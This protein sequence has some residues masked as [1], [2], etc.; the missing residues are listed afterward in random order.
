[1]AIIKGDLEVL[2]KIFARRRVDEGLFNHGSLTGNI[3][4]YAS[5][6]GWHSADP[7]GED[8]DFTLPDATCL[9]EGWQITIHNNGSADSLV[10]KDFSTVLVENIEPNS[11][12]VIT[13]ID[14]SISAGVWF[15]QD[16]DD[17][18]ASPGFNWGRSGNANEGTWL[19]NDT[20]P[21]NKAGRTISLIGSKL[22][23]IFTAN[24]NISTYVI[25]IYEHDGDSI[26]LTLIDSITVTTARGFTKISSVDIT[27]GK[28][29]AAKVISGSAKNVQVGVLLTGNLS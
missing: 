17:T 14:N 25:G 8:R 26:N 7:N 11:S 12:I 19:L 18:S 10:A 3:T 21:S 4:V 1:M 16:L 22:I 27:N 2:R 20:V 9:K 5:T 29:L 13:L 6:H 15:V 28:Q 23:K 24:E